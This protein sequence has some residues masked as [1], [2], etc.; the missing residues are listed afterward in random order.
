MTAVLAAMTAMLGALVAIGVW[1]LII[2]SQR[3]AA[4][5]MLVDFQGKWPDRCPICAFD[6]AAARSKAQIGQRSGHLP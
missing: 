2:Y 6:R 3:R 5:A 1:R 4:R